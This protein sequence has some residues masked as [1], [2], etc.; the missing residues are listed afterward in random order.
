MNKK[1]N[2]FGFNHISPDLTIDERDKFIKIYKNYHQLAYC[3]QLKFQKLSKLKLALHLSS[4]SLTVVGTIVGTVTLNPI[5]AGCVVGAGVIIQAYLAKTNLTQK[6]AQ[7]HL[8]FTSYEKLLNKLKS[9]LR[10]MEYDMKVVLYDIKV[11]DDMV[12]N[13]CP[14]ANEFTKKYFKHYDTNVQNIETLKHTVV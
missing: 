12:I 2:F 11:I 13:Q 6:T 9:Y 4:I 8:A 5:A 7:C 1:I 3:Y 14:S 10:G